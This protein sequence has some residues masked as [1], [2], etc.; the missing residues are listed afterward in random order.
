MKSY[1]LATMMILATL[2]V[3][4]FAQAAVVLSTP[5]IGGPSQ[6]RGLTVSTSFTASDASLNATTTATVDL[7][8]T[9]NAGY[10]AIYDTTMPAGVTRV[11]DTV[12]RIT[13]WDGTQKTLPIKALVP[14][15]HDAVDDT[16]K[17]VALSIGTIAV[18]S[19]GTTGASVPIKMQAE[20]KLHIDNIDITIAGD[21]KSVDDGDDIDDIRVGDSMDIEITVENL[22]SDDDDLDIESVQIQATVDDDDFDIDEDDDVDISARRAGVEAEEP[23]RGAR[24]RHLGDVSPRRR[25]LRRQ[26]A[27]RS[28]AHRRAA[29]DQELPDAH[30]SPPLQ[31]P[32]LSP[33][34]CLRRREAQA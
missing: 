22:Y 33:L 29:R 14:L 6:E 15:S 24:H 18:T 16:L 31:V 25:D 13:S 11:S 10:N 20:N 28:R 2:L 21:S 17:P 8:L 32:S 4:S 19:T 23:G 26:A 3:A 27:L 7:T 5:T 9:N 30:P 12:A 1:V 34:L